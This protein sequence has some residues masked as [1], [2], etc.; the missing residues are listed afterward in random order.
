MS[1]PATSDVATWLGV[2][3]TLTLAMIGGMVTVILQ[4]ATMRADIRYLRRDVKSI[5]EHEASERQELRLEIAEV[6]TGTGQRLNRL[7][8]F[9]MGTGGYG[10]IPQRRSGDPH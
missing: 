10:H 5:A 9:H 2:L 6:R 8:A 7:E 4:W 3:S 1:V